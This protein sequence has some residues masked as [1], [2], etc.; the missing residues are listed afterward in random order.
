MF[1]RKNQSILTP[2]YTALI[3]QDEDLAGGEEDEEVFTLARRDHDLEGDADTALPTVAAPLIS[4]EDL[5]KRKL[6]EGTSR[7]AQLK[8]R[9][10]GEKV[11]FDE[12]GVEKNFYE[13][14]DDAEGGAGA[15]ER[16]NEYLEKERE[17]MKLADKVDRELARE[18]KREKK[19]KRKE[20]E[21]DVSL[22]NDFWA[23]LTLYR[24][25]MGS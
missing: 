18:K 21:R 20:R 2:H 1:E 24:S 16:R 15:E 7:K 3:A 8:N 23:K 12:E 4:S 13:M 9:P 11:V 5:S 14:G 17:R 19:R 22:F 25:S 10:Q 6:R